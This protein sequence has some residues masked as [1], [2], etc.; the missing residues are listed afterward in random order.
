MHD[1]MSTMFCEVQRESYQ[2]SIGKEALDRH[3]YETLHG[4]QPEARRIGRLPRLT[5]VSAV[6]IVAATAMVALACFG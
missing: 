5:I 1:Y 3:T 2:G 6:V 4:P